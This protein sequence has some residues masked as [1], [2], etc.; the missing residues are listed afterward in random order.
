MPLPAGAG[1]R[2]QV[3]Q[4]TPPPTPPLLAPLAQGEARPLLARLQNGEPSSLATLFRQLI[5]AGSAAAESPEA[6]STWMKEAIQTLSNPTQSPAE[7]PFHQLQAK[8]GTALFELPLPWAQGEPLRL[9]IES[10]Q[11]AA[12]PGA[13]P[14][15]RAFLSVSFSGLGDVRLGLE[16][17]PSGL[18]VRLWLRDPE[19]LSP[20]LPGLHEELAAQG[21]PVDIQVLPL[22][23]PAPDLRSLAGGAPLQALG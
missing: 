17:R 7:A 22:P 6:W 21:R 15:Q 19:Q 4:A 3:L 8:E 14:V 20:A 5:Q 10:D 23:D 12:S 16:Q 2:L 9:W 1:I 11:E 13:E 18:R